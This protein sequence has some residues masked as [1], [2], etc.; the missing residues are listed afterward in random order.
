MS[1]RHRASLTRFG[2]TLALLGLPSL[3]WADPRDDARRHFAGALEAAAAKDYQRAVDEFLAA[4]AAIPHAS[5]AFNIAR[6]Y[7]DLDRPEDALFWYRRFQEMM[8]ERAGDAAEA[9]R[10]VQATRQPE[11][12]PPPADAGDA[13]SRLAALDAERA[14]L[15]ERLGLQDT[16]PPEQVPPAPIPQDEVPPT[17][18]E[19]VPAAPVAQAPAPTPAEPV[20]KEALLTNAYDK[21]IV[22]ASRY[23]QDPLDAPASV[24][25][26]SGDDI[27]MSGATNIADALRRAVGV[28]V[29]SMSSGVPYVGVRGFNSEMTNKVLWLVDGRPSALEFLATPM[30]VTLPVALEEIDRIEIIRGPGSATYGANAVTGVINI[31][32]RLPGEGPAAQVSIQGGLNNYMAASA[33]SS[34]GFGPVTYRVSAGYNQEGRFEKEVDAIDPDGIIQG[35]KFDQNLGDQRVRASARFDTR[36]AE[37]GWASLSGGW[38]KGFTEYYSKA[39][40]GNF[41]LEGEIGHV[42]ADVGYGPLHI[43]AVYS[44]EVGQTAPWLYSAGAAR[45]TSAYVG[46]DI[47]DVEIEGNFEARTG[48]VDHRIHVGG[49]IR[50]KVYRAGVFDQG[51]Q[52]PRP[53]FHASVFGQY[54]LSYKWLQA[55]ASLRW[56]RHPLIDLASTVSP[57]G[58]LVFRVADNT[59]IRTSA[60]TAFRAMN[61]LES[62]VNLE[63]NTAA[64]G[65]FV[66]FYG[67][68]T[69]PNGLTLRPE[70]TTNVELGFRDES[71]AFHAI[72]GAVYWNRLTDVIDIGSVQP[73]LGTFVDNTS[74]YPFGEASWVNDGDT[75]Y[76]AVGADIDLTLFPVDGLDIF[77]NISIERIFGTSPQGNFLDES[78]P[79]IRGNLGVLYRAPFRM[80]FT[81]TG[82]YVG[83]EVWRTPEFD[84]VGQVS[85]NVREIPDRFLLVARIAGRPVVKPELELAVT[86]WNPLGFGEGFREHPDGQ[87]VAPRVY[88]SASIAF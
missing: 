75:T 72:D 40:L 18:V 39:A 9:I 59:S 64:D 50:Y 8:P 48:P 80:D 35:F 76:D 63:L 2:V 88:G 86:L 1:L 31:I 38:S 36:F 10:R 73:K 21:V 6:G 34:G 30:P 78:T 45:S 70:R 82:H 27:R 84:S 44:K 52:I 43:R 87:I 33:T 17:T 41:G 85:L 37:K 23:S 16:L 55:T 49:G 61:G 19:E 60:G 57:R 13:R 54:Q 58:A 22:T 15:L 25:V 24:T 12:P 11:T 56:D 67:A 83:R 51:F 42:R 26:I 81:L 28:D 71:S 3:A 4:Y 65:Y 79:L 20:E 14:Q 77:A 62:Y 66:N 74:G 46:D 29:M 32:T 5:T 7:E 69:N 53:E 47:A 68:A